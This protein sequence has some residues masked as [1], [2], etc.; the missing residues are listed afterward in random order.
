MAQYN[1]TVDGCARAERSPSRRPSSFASSWMR[2][3]RW[4]RTVGQAEEIKGGIPLRRAHVRARV[5]GRS[6]SPTRASENIAAR[7]FTV[8]CHHNNDFMCD[9]CMRASCTVGALSARRMANIS[10]TRVPGN[11]PIDRSTDPVS[12][13][14]PVNS[15]VKRINFAYTIILFYFIEHYIFI[16]HAIINL[17]YKI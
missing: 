16:S 2:F 13:V 3:H 11:R 8:Y 7:P 12:R 10:T 9:G 15:R 5:C 4:M 1:Q 17:L 14:R 6:R